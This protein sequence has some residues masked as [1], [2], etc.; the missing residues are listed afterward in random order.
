MRGVK[1]ER[2]IRVL[3][4]E[5][6]ISK[7]RLSKLT[8]C[9][10]PWV[11]EFIKILEGKKLIKNTKVINKEKLIKYWLSIHKNPKYKE[12]MIQKPLE[13]LKGIKLDY[14]LTTYQADNL[15]EHFLFPSRTDIYIKEHDLNKWHSSIVK[16]GLYGKGNFR[17]IIADEHVFYKIQDINGFNIVSLPQLILDLKKE[18]GV[19]GEAAERL[20]MR[21][22]NV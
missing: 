16:K 20:L 9:S 5:K 4:I 1:R 2:I 21:L 14:A 18:G 12:Y 7:Y 13:F 15:F 22:K 10:F 3:L 8:N 11:H 6:N 19:C 17:I